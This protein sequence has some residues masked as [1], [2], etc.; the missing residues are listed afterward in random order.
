MI[1]D[2]N[3]YKKL[4][5]ELADLRQKHSELEKNLNSKIAEVTCERDKLQAYC[6]QLKAKVQQY[7]ELQIKY[8]QLKMNQTSASNSEIQQEID[9]IKAE[10]DQLRKNNWR[11]ME[12][13]N[14]ITHEQRSN[15]SKK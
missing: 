2:I 3:K 5:K 6:D 11:N 1:A 4:D 12:E 8:D 10:N 14:R 7:K 15:Q 9:K 13:L